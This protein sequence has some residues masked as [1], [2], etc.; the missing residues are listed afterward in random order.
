NRPTQLSSWNWSND[1]LLTQGELPVDVALHTQLV[2]N[3]L[4]DR[5]TVIEFGPVL[6]T[7]LGRTQL[8]ANL[9]FERTLASRSAADPTQLKYQWQ[10][11]YRWMPGVH[12]GAQGFGEL[13]AW[14]DWSPRQAQ[15]HRAGPA[16]FGSLRLNEREEVKLQAA[17]LMG[18]TYGRRGHMFSTRLAY[19]F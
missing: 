3:R 8:N 2:R 15:S 12:F 7:D 13:G 4:G 10:A 11:R 1:L 19:D 17:W 5:E 14:D 9:F 18:K 16:V 6:Q